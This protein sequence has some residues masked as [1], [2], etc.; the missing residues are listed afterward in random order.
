MSKL[1][2][3]VV[4]RLSLIAKITSPVI[5]L[6]LSGCGNAPFNIDSES[7]RNA[8]ISS[9]KSNLN[10]MNCGAALEKASELFESKYSDNEIRMLYASALGC[11]ADFKF[12]TVLTSVS[13][14]NYDI[15]PIAG[16]TKFFNTLAQIFP[17]NSASDVKMQSFWLMQDA[18]QS[19]LL[20]NTVVSSFDQVVINTHN[21]GSILSRDRTD[22]A[23]ILIMFSSMALL[24]VSLSRYGDPV[25]G[26]YNQQQTL[27]TTWPDTTA[28]KIDTTKAGCA[29]ATGLFNMNDGVAELSKL[30]SGSLGTALTAIQLVL[31]K[32]IDAGEKQCKTID[33]VADPDVDLRCKNAMKRL[34]FRDACYET[35][36]DPL[37]ASSVAFGVIKEIDS[38]WAP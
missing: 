18:I 12:Y 21:I 17:S 4:A 13:S 11:N 26:S 28:V 24:G 6:L 20:P 37:A 35:D 25:T 29:F 34:R 1:Y 9:I 8:M 38:R 23:N 10:S 2:L 3:P 15:D 30:A 7:D 33:L 14:G 27:Q 22:N 16:T 5:L 36:K 31:D 19:V 32:L